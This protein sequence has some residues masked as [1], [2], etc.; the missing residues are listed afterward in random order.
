MCALSHS[1]WVLVLVLH[2]GLDPP[3]L[4]YRQH[5]KAHGCPKTPACCIKQQIPLSLGPGNSMVSMQ[6]QSWATHLKEKVRSKK[7]TVLFRNS[8]KRSPRTQVTEVARLDNLQQR[9]LPPD[10]VATGSKAVESRYYHKSKLT[11]LMYLCRGN[12]K[13]S[14]RK[15]CCMRTNDVLDSGGCR[16][17]PHY[18]YTCVTK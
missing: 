9:N 3:K 11:C 5:Q 13:L 16:S 15:R 7:D 6:P 18:L 2:N 10:A 14:V 1:K 8:I 4:V 12:M 17:R